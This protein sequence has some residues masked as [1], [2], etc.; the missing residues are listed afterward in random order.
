MSMAHP[1]PF[2]DLAVFL[3]KATHMGPERVS[4]LEEL[5]ARVVKMETLLLDWVQDV[6]F[7]LARR[8]PKDPTGRE[9][10]R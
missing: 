10:A 9:Q 7:R 8:L 5:N 6:E 4:S 1:Q 3:K 2:N